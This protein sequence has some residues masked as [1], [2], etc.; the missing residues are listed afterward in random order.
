[1]EQW[2]KKRA[3]LYA[4]IKLVDE[5]NGCIIVNTDKIMRVFNDDANIVKVEYTDGTSGLLA[6]AE[7]IAMDEAI[8][9]CSRK[10]ENGY[11]R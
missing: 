11:V 6:D 1:M 8:R 2:L 3:A 7:F 4:L 9:K 10:L 5:N